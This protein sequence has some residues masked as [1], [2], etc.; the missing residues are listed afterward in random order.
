VDAAAFEVGLWF[1]GFDYVIAGS[2][3]PIKVVAPHIS[4][5]TS[6]VVAQAMSLDRTKRQPSVTELHADLGSAQASEAT[7]RHWRRGPLH[8]S[9]DACW[10]CPLRAGRQGLS[11]CLTPGSNS[12]YEIRVAYST[13]CRRCRVERTTAAKKAAGLRRVFKSL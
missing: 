3:E 4:D 12:C 6:R 1:G 10:E 8:A 11:P 13:T 7:G 9:H 2:I 5:Y